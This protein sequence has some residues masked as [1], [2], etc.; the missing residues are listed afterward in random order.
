MTSDMKQLCATIGRA[1]LAIAGEQAQEQQA[2][3][4]RRHYKLPERDKA[5]SICGAT[6]KARGNRAKYCP[7]CAARIQLDKLRAL[8]NRRKAAKTQHEPELPAYVVRCERMHA[9]IPAALCGTREECQGKPLCP[10][11]LGGR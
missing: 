3:P 11:L 4:D 8:E 2:E 1:L 6:F 5:C 9:T 10:H 7:A